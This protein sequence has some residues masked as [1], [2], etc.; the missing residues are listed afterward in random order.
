MASS[1][2]SLHT[3]PDEAELQ[4]YHAQELGA[5]QTAAV[6]AHLIHC[7]ACTAR[8]AALLAE[9]EAWVLRLRTA[10][11]PPARGPDSASPDAAIRSNDI[12]GY[13]ILEEIARGGQG[14]VFRALQKST[15]RE[16]ALKVLREGP[17]A[18]PATR[19]RFER[20]IE[21]AATLDHPHIVTIFDSGETPTR[22]QYVVMDYVRG[23]RL[24]RYLGA[25]APPLRARLA[26]FA[27]IGHA[28][29]YAHQRGVIHRD[30]KPSNVLVSDDGQPHILDFGLAR[31]VA[32]ANVSAVTTAGQVVGTLPY[33]AP[34]QARGL[35]DAADVRGDVYAL[36]VMLYELLAGTFPY[37][38]TGDTLEVLRHIAETPPARL[39]GR[40][41]VAAAL[42]VDEE[43]E[44]IVLKALAKER[45]RRYQTAGDLARDIDHYLAG[46]PIEAKR[47]SGLYVLRK[48]LLRY[49][50]AAGVAVAF[51]VLVTA[52]AVALGVMYGRQVRLRAEAERQAML[53]RTATAEAE[54]QALLARAGEVEAERQAAVA[55]A[56]EANAEQQA[57]A[58]HA[59]E[60]DAQRR[61]QQVRELARFFVLDFDPLIARLPGA[62]PARRALV[63]KG[64]SYLDALAQDAG[65]DRGL[66]RELAAAYIAIGDVQGDPDSASLGD[67]KGALESYRKAE[68]ILDDSLAADPTDAA[69]VAAGFLNRHKIGDALAGLGDHAGALAA[70]QD[71]LARGQRWLADHPQDEAAQRHIANAHQRIGSV[72]QTQKDLDG[73]LKHFEQYMDYARAFAAG[74]TDDLWRRRGIAVALTKLANIHYARHE[75]PAA[76]ENYR[77]FL[78]M[79]QQLRAAHPDDLV[80]RRDVGIAHQWIGIILADQGEREAALESFAASSAVFEA[81]QQDDPQ[82]V[83]APTQLVINWSKAGEIHLAAG[84][85]DEATRSF[86]GA[87]AVVAALAQRQ[88]DRPEVLRLLGVSFYKLVELERAQA[89][90]ASWPRA[91]RAEHWQAARGWLVKCREVFVDMQQRSLLTPSDAAVP[92]ELAA[93]IAAC[94]VQLGTPTTATAPSQP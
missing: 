54:R 3:C 69:A 68:R 45:E 52:S 79:S 62:A 33:M 51:V 57:I 9:H 22:R 88:P 44:T 74:G 31:Q 58:A 8:S 85:R 16:V 75:L 23:R 60:A 37:P 86:E 18:A 87:L 63:Q 17:Y 35:S 6:R 59:A 25:E 71:V 13:E 43:L 12:P 10:G 19:R 72:L 7:P 26:L 67:L 78:A 81:L 47:D 66:Q 5:D 70:Y 15:K 48:T 82:D 1:D 50:V 94:D 14:I 20:A 39:R 92:D 89:Q 32:E 46:E 41:R 27:R 36:G 73:A 90:E 34:E 2:T 77:E 24:D 61:F 11:L 38:V 49:R 29:N 56:A 55:R 30:L 64:L 80:A 93:E 4:G 21:L 91:E 76:L 84:R 53:A 65:A 83:A 42:S 28:V 40:P